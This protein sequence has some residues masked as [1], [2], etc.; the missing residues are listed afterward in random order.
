MR[1]HNIPIDWDGCCFNVER[2]M[3]SGYPM[4]GYLYVDWDQLIYGFDND[5]E[6]IYC[7]A[8]VSEV[9]EFA[10]KWMSSNWRRVKK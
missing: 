1:R 3:P 8:K 6:N 5:K 4:M 7:S 10:E 2:M 9:I